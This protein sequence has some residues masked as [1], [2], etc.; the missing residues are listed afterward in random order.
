MD[1]ELIKKLLAKVGPH[2]RQAD[3]FEDVRLAGSTL[4][5]K[6]RHVETD[7]DYRVLAEDDAVWVGLYTPD[8]WLSES[9]EAELMHLGDKIE[10]LLEEE[11]C[12]QGYEVELPVQHFRDEDMLYVFRSTVP[13]DGVA[14]GVDGEAYAQRVTS[15]LLAYEA[16][17]RQ[18]GDMTEKDEII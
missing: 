7:A 15:V 18:L 11:L 5:C 9:I 12:D 3:V 2:A 17:F 8:R 1:A 13:Q 16:C 4:R 6:A 14:D 10:E